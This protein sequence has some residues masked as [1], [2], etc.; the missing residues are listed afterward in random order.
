MKENDII[1]CGYKKAE[2]QSDKGLVYFT[3]NGVRLADSL[4]GVESGLWPVIHIQKKVKLLSYFFKETI[5]L[6]FKIYEN[7]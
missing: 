4:D 7:R 1:G 6:C 2:D 5:P 3:C